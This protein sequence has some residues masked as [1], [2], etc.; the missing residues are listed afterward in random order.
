MRLV[1]CIGLAGKNANGFVCMCDSV[2]T[3]AGDPSKVAQGCN[4]A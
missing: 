3:M 4:T 1:K 2:P